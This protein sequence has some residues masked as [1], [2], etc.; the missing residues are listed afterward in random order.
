[1]LIWLLKRFAAEFAFGFFSPSDV[2]GVPHVHL[3]SAFDLESLVSS[4]SGL[5]SSRRYIDCSFFG[6]SDLITLGWQ[7][8]LVNHFKT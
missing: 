6:D 7:Y 3:H 1:M 5:D 8:A 4:F 2:S